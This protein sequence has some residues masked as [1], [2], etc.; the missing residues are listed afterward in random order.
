MTVSA[1]GAGTGTAE[2]AT[3]NGA[4]GSISAGA[5]GASAPAASAPPAAAPA[6]VDIK[7]LIP[8]DYR[9]R[10]YL[11]DVDT[12]DKLFKKL[13]G[14]QKLIGQRPAGIPQENAP[15]EE[16]DKFYKTL[17]RPEKSEEY[18]LKTSEELAKV[19]GVDEKLAAGVKDLF[20][21]AGLNKKQAEAIQ[22]GY[23]ALL[24]ATHKEA[25]A[26]RKAQDESFGKLAET[27]FGKDADKILATSRALLEAHAPDAVK[28]HLDK[29][30][31]EHLIIL[32]GV[33]DSIQKKYIKED[34]LPAGGM[35]SAG[36]GTEADI[37]KQARELMSTPAYRDQFHKDHQKTIE[38]VNRLYR[39]IK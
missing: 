24:L 13:D 1:A 10:E 18:D 29:L 17:G 11:K 7:A 34:E 25:L 8:A 2:S 9:D 27:T 35:S 28:P 23:E 19:M 38:E 26:Q 39:S 20:Y 15:Q 33:L 36:A 5:M 22:K 14:A 30:S 21:K 37:R 4:S 31:N 6:P 32:A 16:W 3:Q 12:V